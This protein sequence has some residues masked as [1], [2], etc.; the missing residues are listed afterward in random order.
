MGVGRLCE[1][2]GGFGGAALGTNFGPI[3]VSG[4]GVDSLISKF[5]GV[6]LLGLKTAVT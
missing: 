5:P 2:S 4:N 1:S 6:V 3:R